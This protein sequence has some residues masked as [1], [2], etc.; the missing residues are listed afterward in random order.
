MYV[1]I[2]LI[3]YFRSPWGTAAP[4]T[5][6]LILGSSRPPDPP[7]KANIKYQPRANCVYDPSQA[8]SVARAPP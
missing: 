8:T 1:F 3:I 5:P 2:Y 7:A 4:Q 6:R